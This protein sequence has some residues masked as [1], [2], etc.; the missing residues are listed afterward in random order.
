MCCRQQHNIDPNPH[1]KLAASNTRMTQAPMRNWGVGSF[2]FKCHV[3]M[4]APGIPLS[5]CLACMQTAFKRS[6][7]TSA[8]DSASANEGGETSGKD[9]SVSGEAPTS[10]VI[11]WDSVKPDDK[12][13]VFQVCDIPVCLSITVWGES[14]SCCHTCLGLPTGLWTQLACDDMSVL[15]HQQ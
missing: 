9:C 12:F 1:E 10:D 14:D 5:C 3:C 11:D 7:P 2:S 13:L 6:S 15:G 4:T 8:T